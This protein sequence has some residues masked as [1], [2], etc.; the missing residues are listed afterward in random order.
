MWTDTPRQQL[1]RAGLALPQKRAVSRR[2]MTL[3]TLGLVSHD[4]STASDQTGHH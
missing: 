2:Y 3:E 4:P 1:A